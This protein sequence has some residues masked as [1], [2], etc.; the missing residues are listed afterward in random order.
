LIDPRPGDRLA[1][2]RELGEIPDDIYM[3]KGAHTIKFG[4]NITRVQ[5]YENQPFSA[6]GAFTWRFRP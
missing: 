4:A 2:F 5:K 6:A 1:G 3:T